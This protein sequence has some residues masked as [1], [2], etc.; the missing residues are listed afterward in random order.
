MTDKTF[1]KQRINIFAGK[2]IDPNDDIQVKETLEDLSIKLPQNSNF[3]DALR[4]ANNGHDIINLI[5]K[6]RQAK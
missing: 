1:I 3:D 4:M 6:Y 5:I 2:P